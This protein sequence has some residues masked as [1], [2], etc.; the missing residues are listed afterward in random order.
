MVLPAEPPLALEAEFDGF[1]NKLTARLVS[2]HRSGHHAL[3]DAMAVR[4]LSVTSSSVS[5]NGTY[6]INVIFFHR[7]LVFLRFC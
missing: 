4:S 5:T 2:L 6:A 7:I 1:A 3:V